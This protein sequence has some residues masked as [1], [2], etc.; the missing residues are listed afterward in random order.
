MSR[1]IL[2]SRMYPKP[3]GSW[4]AS[5]SGVSG[6]GVLR[7]F[8]SIPAVTA[9]IGSAF[10]AGYLEKRQVTKR[11][12]PLTYGGSPGLAIP[13]LRSCARPSDGADQDQKPR[14]GGLI[15]G[16]FS[17]KVIGGEHQSHAH[18]KSPVG[19]GL[20]ANADWHSALMSTDT[21]SF[22][23]KP[24]PTFNRGCSRGGNDQVS[25][26][27]PL[28]AQVGPKAA[29]RC[30]GGGR[31]LERPSGGSAQWATRPWMADGGGPT[32]QDRKEG[33]PSLGEAPNERGK[34]AWYLAL[35]QVTRR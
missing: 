26:A 5:D 3:C 24:A 19:A 12:A 34:S 31:H 9:A 33:M 35:L 16:L 14:R 4:L 15:A 1:V 22:A 13:L 30:C 7:V 8:I 2:F 23:S 29:S 20:L 27:R 32:E 10:T 11:Q 25:E 6:G 28:D 17:V 18:Q 21:A